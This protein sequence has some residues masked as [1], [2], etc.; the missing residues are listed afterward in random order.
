MATS[1]EM[2]PKVVSITVRVRTNTGAEKDLRVNPYESDA[3][4]WGPD[5]I[6]KLGLPYYVV[7]HGADEA[8]ELRREAQAELN[9]TGFIIGPHKL[10]CRIELAK[11]DWEGPGPFNV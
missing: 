4:F 5:A 9:R 10:Y 8:F 1:D 3:L 2:G 6:D 11:F 7:Q